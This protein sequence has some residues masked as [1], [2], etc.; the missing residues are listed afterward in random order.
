MITFHYFHEHF[1]PIFKRLNIVKVPDLVFLNIAV[2]MYK[3]Y[4]R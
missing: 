1:S 2:L 4:N 3:F